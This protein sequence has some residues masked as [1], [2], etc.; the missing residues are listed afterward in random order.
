MFQQKNPDLFT[1]SQ[2][3][4]EEPQANEN[5]TLG[6]MIAKRK[7]TEENAPTRVCIIY[8]YFNDTYSWT[9]D[10]NACVRN[11]RPGSSGVFKFNSTKLGKQLQY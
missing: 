1:F 2:E 4:I 6:Y 10:T 5:I 11:I 7:T 8:T 3:P 9:V